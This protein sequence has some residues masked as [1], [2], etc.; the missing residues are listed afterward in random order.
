[1]NLLRESGWK[2][3]NLDATIVAENP[4]LA[5]FIPEIRDLIAKDMNIR[6]SQVNIKAT[7]NDKLGFIGQKEGIA[8]LATT[9]LICDGN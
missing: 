9:L 2:V 4:T 6:P 7:T 1:M 5:P 3:G 8:V